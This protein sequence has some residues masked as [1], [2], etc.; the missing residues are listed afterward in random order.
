MLGN[1]CQDVTARISWSRIWLDPR[2]ARAGRSRTRQLAVVM[3]VNGD[4]KRE[5]GLSERL[6]AVKERW[7]Q[8]GDQGALR[9]ALLELLVELER[10]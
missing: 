9:V 1:E 2:T 6:A 3:S 10:S 5:D 8:D 4:L 7:D